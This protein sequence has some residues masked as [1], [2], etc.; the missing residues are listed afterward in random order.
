MVSVQSEMRISLVA[1]SLIALLVAGCGVESGHVGSSDPAEEVERPPD[2]M[3]AAGDDQLALNPFAYCWSSRGQTVCAD[4][5]PPD[6]LPA[7]TVNGGESLTIDFP[8]D[9]TL[10]GTLYVGE[11]Y[12]DGSS[13]VD[14]DLNDAA[15]EELGPAGTYRV[16]VFG[17]GEEGDGAWAF[18]LTTTEDQP[19]P[20]PFVQ[21]LWYPS[22]RD[23]DEGASFGAQL[24]NLTTKPEKVSAVV[25]VTS[26][27][28]GSED[29]ELQGDVD[30]NCWG[31]TVGFAGPDNLTA[32]VLELGSAPYDVTISFS[33]DETLIMSPTFTWPDDFPSNSNESSRKT[34]D[35]P[36]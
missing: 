16:E 14:I 22:D 6:P 10:Q 25:T 31:S 2:L 4:G 30:D 36:S 26:A 9:W 29:F 18:E 33:L 12:C 11:G 24:G 35:P 15:F 5:A 32:Q 13:I 34:V 8:L 7:L 19:G 20:P 21:V 1:G 27:D 28:G 17:R 3:V 23:L